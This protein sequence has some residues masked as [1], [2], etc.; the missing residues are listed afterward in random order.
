[1][2][3]QDE[4]G[5][6]LQSSLDIQELQDPAAFPHPVTGLR[7]VETHIS[8]V[9]LTGEFAYKVKKPVKLDFID[10]STLQQRQHYCNEELVLNRRLAPELYLRVVPITRRNGRALVDGAGTAIEYAVCLKQFGADQELPALLERGDVSA[11]EILQLGETLA[12]FHTQAP[13]ASGSQA[14]AATQRSYDAVLDNLEQLLAHTALDRWMPQLQRL[15]DWTRAAIVTHEAAFEER[16]H[17]GRI[18]DCHGDLH[19]ANI[20]RIDRRLVPF[21]CIDFDPQL[22]WID[23]MNDI[24]FLVMDLHGHGRADLA[25]LLLNRYLEVTGDY[26]GVRLLPFYAVYRALVRAKVDALAIEQAPRLVD[27]YRARLQRR[28]QTAIT[29]TERPAPVLLLMHGLSGS[30]KSWLSEQLVAPLRAL[31]I[32]SDVERQRLAGT[33]P[34]TAAFKQG[35][36]APEMSHRVY[37][38][39]VE[40]A[41]S[42]LQAGCNVI[43]DA[44]FLDAG[45]RE[46]FTGL[47]DRLHVTCAFISCHADPATLLNRVAARSEHGTDASEAGPSVVNAQLRDFKPLGTQRHRPCIQADTR[48]ADVVAMVVGAVRA[49]PA[50]E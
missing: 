8:W 37:A 34:G 18:R 46:L 9:V 14:V 16:A 47:A 6:G 23:V 38:R 26:E 10:T 15:W 43:V 32:R 39:L 31:R 48:N 3:E 1:M 17:A 33:A 41:E 11:Q 21:D 40:C 35:R 42:C 50:S 36:Y 4:P 25:T 20:V 30:G 13:A 28:V 2:S 27:R 45:D 12:H 5:A 44:A 19:A 24:A 49:L 22:R 7:L 29:F